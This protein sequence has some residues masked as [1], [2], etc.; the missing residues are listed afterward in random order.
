MSNIKSSQAFRDSLSKMDFLGFN[1][2]MVKHS[3]V[4]ADL[5][6]A[7]ARLRQVVKIK[8]NEFKAVCHLKAYYL[9]MEI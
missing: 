7:D 9:A 6:Q 4:I 5:C 8:L 3:A 2:I 1:N